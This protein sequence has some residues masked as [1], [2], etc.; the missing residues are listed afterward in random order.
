MDQRVFYKHSTPSGVALRMSKL[1]PPTALGVLQY[2]GG[3]QESDAHPRAGNALLLGCG[4]VYISI[5]G[6]PGGQVQPRPLCYCAMIRP[7]TSPRR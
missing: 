5:R 1:Q 7:I 4:V 2:A 6:N 3:T